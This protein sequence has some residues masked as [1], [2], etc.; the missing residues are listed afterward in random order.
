M[1]T[2]IINRVRMK[3]KILQNDNYDHAGICIDEPSSIYNGVIFKYGEVKFAGE[4]NEDGSR[5]LTFDWDLIYSNNVDEKLLMSE[6]FADIVGTILEE[7]IIES[8]EK[9]EYKYVNREDCS[10]TVN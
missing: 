2:R 5:N 4:E 1:Q 8:L 6:A 7:L 10:S 9:G 3:Y